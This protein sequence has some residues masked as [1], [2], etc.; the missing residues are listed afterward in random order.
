M[1]LSNQF[2]LYLQLLL[3]LEFL[4]DK[5]VHNMNSSMVEIHD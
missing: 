3:V 5:V 4:V 2:R 1:I